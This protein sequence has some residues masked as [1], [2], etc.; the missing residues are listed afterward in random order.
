LEIAVGGRSKTLYDNG[1][2]VAG[3][4]R[5]DLER[6]IANNAVAGFGAILAVAIVAVV[7]SGADQNAL[8]VAAILIGVTTVTVAAGGSRWLFVIAGL[9][10]SWLV[11]ALTIRYLPG[12]LVLQPSVAQAVGQASLD[13]TPYR[14]AQI[15]AVVSVATP[16]LI[17]LAAWA[18]WRRKGRSPDAG[19][20]QGSQQAE[21]PLAAPKN[22][23]LAMRVGIAL[24][25]FSIVPDLRTYLDQA[26]LP[27]AYSW[28]G[29]NLT[30][31]QGFIQLG[32]TP[33]KD[34]FFPYGFQWLYA[35][36]SV[37]PLYEWAAQA[38]M[39]A[40]AGWSLWRLTNGRTW[41][42]LAC[43][44]G[45]L[46]IASWDFFTVTW[47]GDPTWRFLP[48]LLIPLSYAAAGPARHRQ[49]VRGHAVFGAACFL[50]VALEPDLLLMGIAGAILV[51]LGEIVSGAL[52]W[53][54]RLIA[55][56]ALLDAVPVIGS[57]LLVLL[58]WLATGTLAGN[59]RFFAN[60]SAASAQSALNEQQ[61]GALTNMVIYP[62][63]TSLYAVTPALLAAAGFITAVSERHRER[64]GIS[65]VLLGAAGV[66]VVLLAIDFVRPID[67]DVVMIPLVAVMWSA[68]LAWRG[69]AL[70]RG[71]A[72]GAALA[73]V[74]T[75]CN[76]QGGDFGFFNSAI[77]APV[78]AVRSALVAVQPGERARA[79][80]AFMNSNRF[81][82]WPDY[83]AIDDLLAAVPKNQ[84]L[85]QF[86][87]IGDLPVTYLL[88][89]QKPP[90]E[91]E[92]YDAG[93]LAEQQ[94]MVNDL[95]REQPPYLIWSR[96]W[97]IDSVPSQVR[98][99]LVYTWM[100]EHYV[101]TRVQPASSGFAINILRRRTPGEPLAGAFFGAKMGTT[102]SLGYIP[103]LSG[104]TASPRCNGG[105]G[106]VAYAVL[107][108]TNQVTGAS[109]VLTITSGHTTY[110]VTFQSRAGVEDYAVRLD[111]LWFWPLVSAHATF[112]TT[113]P[114]D[115]VREVDLRSGDNLY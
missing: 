104:A 21:A 43:L 27:V 114:G 95:R 40:I 3:K 13:D 39:F 45:V 51:F 113:T 28:D 19:A 66:S 86:A 4:A 1:R 9:L 111:R 76:D 63:L 12:A 2:A 8:Q 81:A 97:D 41:R 35:A 105:P 112:A 98:D 99:P 50:A 20:K 7:T 75:L 85:P 57:V 72:C 84:A 26:S 22:S 103:S 10:S 110:G 90:W 108:E 46:M 67:E 115:S 24:L 106:C 109:Q 53:R 11:A 34:F 69:S 80:A 101:P 38:A 83:Y 82:G 93:P 31:W 89:R 100:V 59:L 94:T 61:L 92:L 96:V 37:G 17:A 55:R 73:A 30:A 36:R 87:V 78:R 44:L 14:G 62:T 74:L 49:L 79:A 102:V 107:H 60:L 64:S 71:I 6:S 52:P 33:M 68:I 15:A 56:G 5:A 23:P 91:V 48:A 88:L 29:A 70:L 16:T 77:A 18:M 32:L 47:G 25:V 65:A 58:A 54:P 42:V